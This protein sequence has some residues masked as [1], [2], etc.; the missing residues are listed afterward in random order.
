V[1]RMIASYTTQTVSSSSAWPLM[2][3]ASGW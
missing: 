3:A 2:N 1:S